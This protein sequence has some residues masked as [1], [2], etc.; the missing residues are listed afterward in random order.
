MFKKII[1]KIITKIINSF[2]DDYLI[3][4]FTNEYSKNPYIGVTSIQKL[5]AKNI[6]DA[7]LR[8]ETGKILSI[9]Y[10]SNIVL[11]PWEKI[12]LNPRQV[13]K[14][15][16]KKLSEI[17]TEVIIGKNCKRPL[18]L[19]MP[20]MI[21]GMSYGG[22]LSFKMKVALAKGSSIA[23]VSTNTGESVLIKE[24]RNNA[25]YVIG[26]LHRGNLMTDEELKLLDAIEIRLGQGAWGGNV[27]SITYAEDID[28]RLKKD[29]RLKEGEDKKFNS[30]LKGINSGSDLIKVVTNFKKKYGVPI[31]VKIAATDF[32]EKELDIITNTE[33]DYIVIDGNEG[34]TAVAPPTLEDNVGLPTLFALIRAVRYLQKR[35]LKEKFD[36]II[37][38]GLTTPGYFLKALA[39]GADAVY[40]GSIA[41]FAA[42]HNQAVKTLPQLPPTE[43]ALNKGT[44]KDQLNITLAARALSN[45]LISCNEEMK[46][47]LQA[48]SKNKI[49]ELSADDLV[50]LDKDI[51]NYSDIRYV[52]PNEKELKK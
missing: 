52:L 35:K 41:V 19:S 22:S 43:L 47:A 36:L 32:I 45:F 6:I 27:E 48:M 29:W 50:S 31:G 10:G 25:K 46:L 11:S 42:V 3:Q 38:G 1:T 15:P 8:A 37:T 13:F 28:D 14:F 40:I 33:C 12:L 7:Q 21:T 23:G 16:T 20:I 49:T 2:V 24:V 30:R 34:G 17:N 39:I 9:P 4:I 26:Q 5:G 18:K 51:S 44:Y